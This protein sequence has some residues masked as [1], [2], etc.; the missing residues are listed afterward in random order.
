MVD[1]HLEFWLTWNNNTEM[2]RL[3][4]LP[5]KLSVKA[6]QEFADI[7]LVDVG[8]ATIIGKPELKEYTFSS[9]WPERYDPGICEYK[10]FPSPDVFVET[11]ERWRNTGY[12]IRFTVTGGKINTPATIRDFSYEWDGFD[13]EFSMSLKEYRFIFLQSVDVNIEFGAPRNWSYRPDTQKAKV[14][15][16]SEK[17]KSGDG[18][19]EKE[20]LVDKYLARGKPKLGDD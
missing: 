7:S 18:G 14:S 9:I 16:T 2:L 13:L 11:I 20:K 4:V 10:G 3:P 1:K 17:K 5:A 8:G 15:S 19:G 6:G 12:P